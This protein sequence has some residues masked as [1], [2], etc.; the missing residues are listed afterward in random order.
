MI[1]KI[2]IL[3]DGVYLT[4]NNSP[5]KSSELEVLVGKAIEEKGIRNV[6]R[7]A[8]ARLVTSKKS[9]R[10]EKISENIVPKNVNEMI[11]LSVSKDALMAYLHFKKPLNHGTFL[12]EEE[13]RLFLDNKGIVYG[14]DKTVLKDIIKNRK[15]DKDYLVAKGEAAL[16]GEDGRLELFFDNSDEKFKPVILENGNVD[17]YNIK[18]VEMVEEGQVLIRI[19][20][21]KKGV[22]GTNVFGQPIK[23]KKGKTPTKI[24][25]GR[26]VVVKSD[27][28]EIVSSAHG[29]VIFSDRRIEVT[30]VMEI[31][32]DVGL[33]TGNI[34]FNGSVIVNGNLNG[35]SSIAAV[36]NVEV[37]GLCEGNI[38]ADGS[39]IVTGGISG[40]NQSKI[41]A[42]EHIGAKF[43]SNSEV[44][45]GGNIHTGDILHS[46]VKS[47]GVVTLHGIKGTVAGG[48]IYAKRSL[49]ANII[50]A[51]GYGFTKVYAGMDYE[52][53]AEYLA[54][55][56]EYK[57]HKKE[58]EEMLKTIIYFDKLA[59]E[60]RLNDDKKKH[61]TILKYSVKAYMRQLKTLKNEVSQALER[62]END[63]AE[64]V[65]RAKVV[66]QNVRIQMGNAVL[67][68]KDTIYD[69]E[70]I[71]NSGV[72][73]ITPFV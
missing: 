6:D 49:R 45:A 16:T 61:C 55:V 8:V 54:R 19:H 65:I 62:L 31:K 23:A 72:V 50:G 25:L 59:K 68:V 30:K 34:K 46:T 4:I 47:K 9:V 26:N 2:D 18:N 71:N 5:V 38:K 64:G 3:E 69:S 22:D 35:D 36:G 51:A 39:I 58:C 60:N 24:I 20:K 17:Y 10:R 28:S 32:G 52:L 37:R 14:I 27:G 66:Y 7:A 41:I 42:G 48:E 63:S 53:L 11:K 1:M 56:D 44:V 33:K 12:N 57:T 40:V 15:Y 70:F 21:G 43:V 13:I 29:Q 67:L 73:R